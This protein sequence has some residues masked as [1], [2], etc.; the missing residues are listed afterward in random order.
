MVQKGSLG[1]FA[2][3]EKKTIEPTRVTFMPNISIGWPQ[4][5][6]PYRKPPM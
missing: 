3:L 6:F 1:F 5:S 2:V 4:N